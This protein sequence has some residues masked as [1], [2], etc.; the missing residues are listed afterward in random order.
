METPCLRLA[1]WGAEILR[2][3]R[4]A[5]LVAWRC[6]LS[7]KLR[8]GVMDASSETVNLRRQ[9]EKSVASEVGGRGRATFVAQAPR[10]SFEAVNLLLYRVHTAFGR[11]LSAVRFVCDYQAVSAFIPRL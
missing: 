3:W 10:P 6:W 7:F 2:A 11:M 8:Q 5:G 9:L 1:H 4:R